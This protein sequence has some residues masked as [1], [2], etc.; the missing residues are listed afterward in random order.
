MSRSRAC[1][2]AGPWIA[3][4][5]PAA[6]QTS[7]SF[8][9]PE[10]DTDAENR[11]GSGLSLRVTLGEMRRLF[12]ELGNRILPPGR[13]L[14]I[15]VLDIDLAGLDQFGATPPYGLRVV[16]DI[17]PPRFVL[18]YALKKRGRAL[19]SGRETVTDLDF[20]TRYA[21]SASS[22]TFTYERALIRDWL[23]SRFVL[24]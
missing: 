13:T 16:T 1:A 11:S 18:R 15:E 24:R 17:T 6:A 10:R 9:Q 7:V 12:T 8:I 23:Q 2:F 3:C 5:A 20:L 14:A 19:R 22:T 4:A 21:R